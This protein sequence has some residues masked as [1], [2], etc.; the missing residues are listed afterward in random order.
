MRR[1]AFPTLAL[2]F[3][4]ACAGAQAAVLYKLVD[5]AGNVTFADAVPSGFRG[6]ITRIDVDTSSMPPTRSTL[7]IAKE[8]VRLDAELAAQR[9]A[10]S[11]R[12]DRIEMARARVEAARAALDYARA[13]ATSEDWV[14]F[15]RPNPV[16][17]ARRMPRPEYAQR[18]QQL[19][20]EVFAAQAELDGLE[21]APL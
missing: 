11:R 17:G 7:D 2:A 3:G 9:L 4:L 12:E 15:V 14:Y 8:S 6:D 10:E 16:T 5:P 20:N 19:E 13:N 21:R 1:F 18:L